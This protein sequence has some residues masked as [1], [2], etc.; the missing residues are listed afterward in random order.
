MLKPQEIFDLG[1]IPEKIPLSSYRKFWMH[2]K[3]NTS[4]YFDDHLFST[5][6]AGA[7]SKLI[8]MIE[9]SLTSIPLQTGYVPR[10]WRHCL[11]VMILKKAGSTDLGSQRTI[12]LFPMDCNYAFK[13]VGRIMMQNAER[14]KVLAPEQYGSRKHHKATDL[15]LNKTLTYNI[16]RQLKRPGSMCSNDAKSCYDLIGHTQ[17]SLAV[18]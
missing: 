7:R 17:A 9:C 10:C 3:E 2:A 11:D 6:K 5:M 1:P 18:Q 4:S 16:P 13:H 12:V 14:A 8:S 15:A